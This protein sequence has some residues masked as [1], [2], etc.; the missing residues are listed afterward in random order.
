MDH[1]KKVQH[2]CND[3]DHDDGF[4]HYDDDSE[5]EHDLED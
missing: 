5:L 4:D 1:C 3:V 2:D